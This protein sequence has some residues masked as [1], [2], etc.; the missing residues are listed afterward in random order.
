MYKTYAILA[1]ALLARG[2]AYDLWVACGVGDVEGA[3]RFINACEDKT[4]LCKSRVPF[5]EDYDNPLVV[6][7]FQGHTP[8]VQL[9]IDVGADPD[10]PFE[11]DVAGEKVKQ[12]GHP[13][14]Y[15]ANRG[16]YEV[17]KLLI[18]NGA[19]PNTAVYASGNA[20]CWAY[21][22]GHKRV[23]DLMFQHGAV[24]DL[25]SYLL[26]NN[27]PAIAESLHRDNTEHK[28]LLNDAVIA[29]NLDM[30]RVAL[31]D[32]PEYD[33]AKGFNLLEAAVRGWRLG[34]LKINNEGFDRR[35]S[36]TI[37]DMLLEYGIDPNLRN[38]RDKR[39]NFTILHHLAGKSCNPVTYGHTAEEV[40]EFARTL[41]NHGADINAMEDKLKSTPLGW[42][43]RFGQKKLV[44]FLLDRG[45][46]PNLAGAPW[47][48]PLA[49]AE[50]RGHTEIAEILRKH[51]ATT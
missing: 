13:L 23:A 48:T 29:G 45:A 27:L 22:Y 6:A 4:Q 20:V 11:M 19:N 35:D 43:A 32:N 49:W 21:Q 16:H 37:L 41:L 8:I 51:G 33:E 24:A 44:E 9:L 30:V 25:L 7:C 26:T 17:V 15:A 10:A 1:G 31:R 40:V 50:K 34:N 28:G 3:K 12:W 5:W 14:W 42:A 36:I 47:A 2:A 18:E 38:P 39:F 46:D